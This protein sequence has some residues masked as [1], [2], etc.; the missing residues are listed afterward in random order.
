M[1]VLELLLETLQAIAHAAIPHVAAD[2]DSH[3]AD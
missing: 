1:G 3:S 2:A